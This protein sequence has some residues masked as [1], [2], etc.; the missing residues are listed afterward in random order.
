MKSEEASEDHHE[1]SAEASSARKVRYRA[2]VRVI[3]MVRSKPRHH[4]DPGL[5]I[6]GEVQ[7]E[8][9]DPW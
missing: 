3:A 9:E 1:G 8:G 7:R 2:C 4:G 5:H 6:E